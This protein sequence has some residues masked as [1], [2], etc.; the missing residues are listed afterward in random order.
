VKGYPARDAYASECPETELGDGMAFLEDPM[1]QQKALRLATELRLALE[2]GCE[3]IEIAGSVRRGKPEVKDIEIV[4]VPT[5]EMREARNLFNEEVGEHRVNLLEVAL[6]DLVDGP[7]W[8]MDP[9]LRRNGDRYKRLWNI[10]EAIAVDLFITT[11]A[12]WGGAL[13][14]RTGPADFSQALVTLALRQRKHVADGYLVHGHS[15][16]EG[17][18]PKGPTCPLIVPTPTE[19]AF[20]EALGLRWCEPKDR[21]TEWLWAEAKREVA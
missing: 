21:T 15:K 1:H 5:I 9:K 7:V 18:C 4:A 13:A 6:A 8:G 14:I 12:G 19:E 2:A 16:P 3:Q 17:G 11:S 20:F 10:M